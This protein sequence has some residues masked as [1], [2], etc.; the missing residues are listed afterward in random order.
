LIQAIPDQYRLLVETAIET[1]MRWGELIALRPR[2]IDFLTKSV[3]VE[4]TIIEVSKKH[5]PTGERYVTKPYP[6]DNEP[7]TFGV[8]DDW[9]QAVSLHIQT[10]GIGRDQ[11]LFT[12]AQARQSPAIP[13]APA[14]GCPP[15]KPVASTSPCACTTSATH[16]PPGCSPKDPT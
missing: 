5:S 1:G 11:P 8:D 3:T 4:E 15:S 16:T 6:K 12:T 13:S 2:H 9:L 14:S 10:R 7:R